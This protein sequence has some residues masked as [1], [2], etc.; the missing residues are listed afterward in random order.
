MFFKE[1][2][3]NESRVLAKVTVMDMVLGADVDDKNHTADD[4]HAVF[5]FA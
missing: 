5:V 1:T 2:C 3:E 4:N